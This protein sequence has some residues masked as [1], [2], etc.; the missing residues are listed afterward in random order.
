MADETFKNLLI[1]FALFTIFTWLLINVAVNFGAEYGK[2]AEEIGGGSFNAEKYENYADTIEGNSSSY[3]ER[4]SKGEIEDVDDVSG[5]FTIL[6]DMVLFITT[7][8]T[9]LADV[10]SNVLNVPTLVTN[11][12]MGIISIVIILAIWKVVKLGY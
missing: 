1:G 7:P 5:T 4:F 3:R 11:V 10:L 6:N 2:S 12:V 8:Y 9:L